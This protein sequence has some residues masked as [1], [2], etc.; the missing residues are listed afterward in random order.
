MDIGAEYERLI[1]PCHVCGRTNVVNRA[2]DLG[3][4]G[5][6]I[7]RELLCQNPD[8]KGT[9]RVT[10]ETANPDYQNMIWEARRLRAEKRYMLAVAAL[11]QAF[12]MFFALGTEVMLVHHVA[13]FASATD[14]QVTELIEELFKAT[15][16]HTYARMRNLFISLALK[17]RPSSVA[18]ARLFIREAKTPPKELTDEAITMSTGEEL[19]K[20]LLR[21]NHL[22]IGTLRNRVIHKYA[23]RPTLPELNE[24]L[25]QATRLTGDLWVNLNLSTSLC[26]A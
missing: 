24:S 13:N 19:A 8:C 16:T 20:L 3:E 18:E 17:N 10:F 12:E 4:T 7:G 25:D 26:G 2:S 5:F 15:R 9:V 6:A 21:L 22:S 23:Y 14:E 1:V 11:T